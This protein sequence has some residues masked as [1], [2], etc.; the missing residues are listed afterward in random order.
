MFRVLEIFKKK[1][2]RDQFAIRY[3]L[4]K[5]VKSSPNLRSIPFFLSL[6][7]N[8]SRTQLSALFKN[9]PQTPLKYPK[10]LM[11]SSKVKMNNPLLIS[12]MSYQDC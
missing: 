2:K 10:G 11:L 8:S 9:S 6:P 3:R 7:P 5:L 1:K 4:L 12:S